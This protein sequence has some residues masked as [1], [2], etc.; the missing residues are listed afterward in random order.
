MYITEYIAWHLRTIII[1]CKCKYNLQA[2]LYKAQTEEGKN[3]VAGAASWP[4]V[5]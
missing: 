5:T 2:N 1:N 4:H 3:K